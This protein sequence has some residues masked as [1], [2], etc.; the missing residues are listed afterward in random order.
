MGEYVCHARIVIE[1]IEFGCA[2]AAHV[3]EQ[4]AF[5]ARGVPGGMPEFFGPVGGPPAVQVFGLPEPR[6]K[7]DEYARGALVAEASVHRLVFAEERA[8]EKRMLERR[9]TGTVTRTLSDS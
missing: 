4:D 8:G 6:P 3:R 7:A 5:G 1:S 9:G 2:G